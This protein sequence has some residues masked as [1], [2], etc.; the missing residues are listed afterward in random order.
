MGKDYYQILG[1]DKTASDD[2]I[3]KAYR[4]MALKYHPDRTKEDKQA[5]AKFKK[6]AEAYEVLSDPD[7]K[8]KYDR[9]GE[10]GL[11]GAFSGRGGGFAWQDFHH[12]TDFEDI[13]SNIFGNFFGSGFSGQR[14][15]GSAKRGADLRVN[16]K[17]TFEEVAKGAE[18]KIKVKKYKKC[19]ACSGT[20]ARSGAGQKTCPTCG[21]TGEIHS[22]SR[23]F[24]GTFI[25]VQACSTC[26]GEGK[27]ISNPCSVC[28][29]SGRSRETETISVNVPAGVIS[30]NYIPLQGRGDTG[31][32]NGPSGDIILYI[33]VLE[34][35]LFERRDDDV[36]YELPISFSQAA[37]GDTVE[38]PTL[39]GRARLKIPPGTQSG[40]IFRMR[41]KGIQHL[42]MHGAG[43]QLVRAWVWTPR[44]VS[45]TEKNLLKELEKSP[46]I[47]PPK[48]GKSFL[49]DRE[50]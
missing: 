36:I 8:A 44:E 30:G 2:E 45:K 34:H 9:F 40:K 47:K 32:R 20:G 22:Q 6:T 5:E 11:K 7:K 4:K 16:L 10:E 46:H 24:F 15:R 43:D 41:G 23:S 29:G 33:D 28:D 38:V 21:G 17:L 37:L 27:V 48:G 49:R 50:D 42:Q 26:N 12:A 14:R 19:S 31:P 13:F 3:K 1:V 25:N 39:D 18:K 35:E